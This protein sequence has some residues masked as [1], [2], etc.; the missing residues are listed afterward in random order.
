MDFQ[1]LE[2]WIPVGA[3]ESHSLDS[4]ISE[5]LLVHFPCWGQHSPARGLLPRKDAIMLNPWFH[6]Q[7]QNLYNPITVRSCKSRFG[8]G[9][10]GPWLRDYSTNVGCWLVS[11]DP[12]V[13][14]FFKNW[15]VSCKWRGWA[16]IVIC[17][18][19]IQF[20]QEEKI[21]SKKKY[22]SLLAHL[23]LPA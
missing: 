21:R 11:W 4:Q 15:W 7:I 17:F 8:R 18:S 5:G 20:F 2:L 16:S 9:C 12:I 19:Q 6:T 10:G 22:P 23:P 3:C 13:S 1:D 14:F